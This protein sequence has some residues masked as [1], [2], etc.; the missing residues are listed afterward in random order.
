MDDE[1][2][3]QIVAPRAFLDGGEGVQP[4]RLLTGKRKGP[5]GT[6]VG[7]TRNIGCGRLGGL[8]RRKAQEIEKIEKCGT[9]LRITAAALEPIS[10]GRERRDTLGSSG[11]PWG[12]LE[13]PSVA[14]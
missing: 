7:G 3:G 4:Q 14:W 6:T 1:R 10:G 13:S 11:V 8:A 12:R 2:K 5:G 9:G